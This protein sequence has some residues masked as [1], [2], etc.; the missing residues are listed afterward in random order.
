[1]VSGPVLSAGAKLVGR[2]LSCRLGPDA[3]HEQIAACDL[4]GTQMLQAWHPG[5]SSL[6]A[7]AELAA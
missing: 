1:M 5:R 4:A 6:R 3:V 7:S 2:G